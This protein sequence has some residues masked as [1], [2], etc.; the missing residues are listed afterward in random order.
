MCLQRRRRPAGGTVGCWDGS[1]QTHPYAASDT[2]NIYCC[3]SSCEHMSVVARVSPRSTDLIISAINQHVKVTELLCVRHTR[4]EGYFLFTA[5]KSNAGKRLQKRKIKG[6]THCFCFLF[7]NPFLS[8]DLC[9]CGPLEFFLL[10]RKHDE[11]IGFIKDVTPSKI[12][13]N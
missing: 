8:S 12:P 9:C 7:L 13:K 11:F 6:Q 10:M 3:F 2:V 4:A 5:R 1:V